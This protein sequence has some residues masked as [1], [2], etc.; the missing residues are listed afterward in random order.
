MSQTI[1][2]RAI[3]LLING[4]STDAVESWCLQQGQPADQARIT[5]AEARKR[6]TVAAEFTR[7]EQLGKAVMRLENIYSKATAD[8]D[9]RTALQAQREL[10][11]LLS[12]YDGRQD[13]ASE[14]QEPGSDAARVLEMI[15]GYLLPLHLAEPTYP[16]QEH[17][18]IA[19]EV[20]RQHGLI[21]K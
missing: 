9:T 1:R 15:A 21:G 19:A 10:N 20:I 2:D 6:I 17:A 18:R 13:S 12:L 4:M 11:R 7:D 8:N 5:V 3:L 14:E 16:V